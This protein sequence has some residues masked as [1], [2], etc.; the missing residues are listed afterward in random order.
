MEFVPPFRPRGW[1]LLAAGLLA[2]VLA[3]VLGRRDLLLVA[4]FCASLPLLACAGL[5]G[6]KPGFSIRRQLT[7]RLARVGEPVSVVLEMRGQ[8]PAGTRTQLTEQLPPSFHENPR[9]SHPR[10]TVPHGLLSRYEYKALPSQRG[11]FTVGPLRGVF[12]D[13]F[14]V[15]FLQRELDAGEQ[16]AVAPAAVALDHIPL[17]DGRGHD[18]SHSNSELANASA[19]DAMTRDYRPGDP[20]R[21]VHWAVTARQGKLM[22]RAEESVTAPEAAIILDQRQAAFGGTARFAFHPSTRAPGH[23][24]AVPRTT[25]AFEK[26]VVAAVSIATHL[27]ERGYTVRVLDQQGDA[28]FASSPS[29]AEPLLED[30]AGP[31]GV[32]DI[33][34]ALAALELSATA[35]P[36][37]HDQGRAGRAAFGEV[38]A[39]K[40]HRGRRRGPIV[41]VVG[42]LS[43]AEAALLA[44][45]GESTQ[46]AAALMVCY[47]PAEAAPALEVLRR[48]GWQ[49]AVVTPKSS[50][51]AAWESLSSAHVTG[52]AS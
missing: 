50:L 10:P 34:V 37:A 8:S 22:V 15:A 41:A 19:D 35:E 42:H 24:P 5:H 2:L 9:F 13:P 1:L 23:A 38:L 46:W 32:V 26:A 17:S 48:A 25:A 39:G 7:P 31:Q 36:S 27:L 12:A 18:G 52:L 49:A 43:A 11:V 47:E 4:I 40:L 51:A 16:L 45:M 28:G 3:W 29:A 33:A 30:Y 20:L 44:S 14:D 21:R 6:F